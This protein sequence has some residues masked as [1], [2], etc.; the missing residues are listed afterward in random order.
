M[1]NTSNRVKIVLAINNIGLFISITITLLIIVSVVGNFLRADFDSLIDAYV[2]PNFLEIVSGFI[3]III[4]LSWQRANRYLDV[5]DYQFNKHEFV[6][7]FGHGPQDMQ[8][9]KYEDIISVK[10]PVKVPLFSR[11]LRISSLVF[12][13]RIEGGDVELTLFN[14]IDAG[15]ADEIRTKLRQK[16]ANIT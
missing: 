10:E 3:L 5:T 7:I 6:W 12:K 8:A 11:L 15:E 16:N 13:Y 9:I 1:Q 2:V 14:S 4:A